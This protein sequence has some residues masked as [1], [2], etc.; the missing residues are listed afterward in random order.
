MNES[1][2]VAITGASSGLGAAMAARFQTGGCRVV[3][4]CR[5]Q[6]TVAVD[7][8]LPADIT[9]P[10]DR[11]RIVAELQARYGRLDVLVNNAGIGLYD[12]WEE[13]EEAALRQMFELNFFAVCLLTQACLP[14]L[15]ASRGTIINTASVA[16]KLPV[17]C[18]GGYCATKY[19]LTAYSDTLRQELAPSGIQ[20]VNLVVGRISTGFTSRS[21][22]GRRAPSTPDVGRAT[23]AGLADAAWRA[24][25]HRRRQAIYPGWYRLVLLFARWWPGLWDAANRRKWRLDR[26]PA[27]QPP[28]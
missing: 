5:H 10:A 25:R 3:A 6:P 26:P 13:T 20:V 19:A 28:R 22:G 23:P 18:M 2:V 1:P 11:A 12:T 9:L 4:I 7:H 17:A 27:E 8:W 14:A 24:W 16:G 15:R 21:L